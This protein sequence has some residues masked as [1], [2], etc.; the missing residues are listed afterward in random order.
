MATD[1][2]NNNDSSS[3]EDAEYEVAPTKYATKRSSPEPWHHGQLEKHDAEMM[4]RSAHGYPRGSFLI[5]DDLDAHGEC[6]SDPAKGSRERQSES[7]GAA[8]MIAC[9]A[10]GPLVLSSHAPLSTSHARAR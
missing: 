1:Y 2:H 10:V 6:Y 8:E 4:L 3:G 7:L 9:V 5:R